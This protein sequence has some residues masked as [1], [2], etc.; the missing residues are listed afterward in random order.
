MARGQARYL[1]ILKNGARADQGSLSALGTKVFLVRHAESAAQAGGWARNDVVPLTEGGFKQA[2]DLVRKIPSPPGL[3]VMSSFLRTQQTA[4]P[5][6]DQFPGVPAEI[7]DVHEFVPISPGKEAGLST[8]ERKPYRRAYWERMDPDYCDGSGAESFSG[9]RRRIEDALG[10]ARRSPVG[11][12]YI[13][14]HSRV[15]RLLQLAGQ[16]PGVDDKVLMEKFRKESDDVWIGNC[17][18]FEIK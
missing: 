13:F 1:S 9:F 6:R 4:Q 7:W 11:P 3:I 2:R 14:T 8:Q 17:E 18:I 10:R 16:N 5:L 15:F 12:V